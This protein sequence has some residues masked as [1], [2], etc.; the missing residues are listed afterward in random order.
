MSRAVLIAALALLTAGPAAAVVPHP[1]PGDPRIFEVLYDPTQVVE[2]HSVLGYQLSL[3]F[4]PAERIENVAI[5][6]AMGWQVTPNRKANLLF[7]KPMAQRPDTNM[8]VVTNLRRYEFQLSVRAKAPAKAI[9]YTVRFVYPPPAVAFVVPP[10]PPAPPEDRNH[11]YSYQGSTKV[12]PARMFD[13]GQAT[14][15]AFPEG[16]DLPAIYAVE[17]D[18]GEAVVNSH[19]RDGY[20]VVDR[21]APAFV[22][23]RGTEVTRVFNDGWKTE[24]VSALAPKA[25]PAK[26]WWRR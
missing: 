2:L 16:G 26:P 24:A 23:R 6:D 22:L 19:V 9:P 11:A 21:T 1:G 15:F 12:L 7:L 4:D 17:A 13:D 5:G 18:G 25:R 14:Y 3:E 20:I 10:P 8:S